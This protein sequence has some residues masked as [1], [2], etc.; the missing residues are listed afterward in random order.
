MVHFP[1][2]LTL[3]CRDFEREAT[4]RI[5]MAPIVFTIVNHIR[6]SNAYSPWIEQPHFNS[7]I[8]LARSV[9]ERTLLSR[10]Q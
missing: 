5:E 9:K 8:T 1:V 2:P 10:S 3:T 6:K 4:S 7:N